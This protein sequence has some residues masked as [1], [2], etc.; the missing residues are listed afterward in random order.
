M[1]TAPTPIEP[2]VE[3]LAGTHETEIV[4]SQLQQFKRGGSQQTNFE[5]LIS[6]YAAQI[7]ELEQFF[8][9]LKTLRTIDTAV[10]VQLEGIGDIVGEARNGRSD[11]DYRRA[12]RAKILINISSGTTE[13]LLGVVDKLLPAS[14]TLVATEDSFPAHFEILVVEPV[15]DLPAEIATSAAE[16]FVLS[17]GM[18]LNVDVDGGG[19]QVVT[20][21][22]ADF[23]DIA[24]AT[25]DEIVAV[26][27]ANL[28]G[29][30]ATRIV[31]RI[32]L[33]S[34]VVGE[35]SSLEITGGTAASVLAFP[36]GVHTGPEAS[37]ALMQKVALSMNTAKGTAI[38]GILLWNV[39]SD[40]FGFLGTTGALGFGAGAFASASEGI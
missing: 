35:T 22:T 12:V 37:Q 16:P 19:V 14:K 38:R 1:A 25:A 34:D 26:L 20:F 13:D 9:T 6:V 29:A 15:N 21:F 40:S 2:L 11:D 33:K 36:S 3:K 7:Q 30:T 31:N 4:D 32:D 27:S 10:G 24:A 39:S 28:T 5:K 17:D 23:V 18:T 8:F